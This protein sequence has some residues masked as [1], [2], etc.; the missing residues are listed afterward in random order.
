[1]TEPKAINAYMKEENET[2]YFKDFTDE[3][4]I[5]FWNNFG[6]LLSTR[7]SYK[8]LSQEAFEDYLAMELLTKRE[9]EVLLLKEE[10]FQ[11]LLYKLLE[12]K[13]LDMIHFHTSYGYVSDDMRKVIEEE[14]AY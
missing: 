3:E 14:I 8:G 7:M 6:D 1:M 2:S 9:K 5:E 10:A 13:D 11:E 12:P 4:R